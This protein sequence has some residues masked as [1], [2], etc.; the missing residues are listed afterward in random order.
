MRPRNM[1]IYV[2]ERIVYDASES[3]EVTMAKK[4]K[5]EAPAKDWNSTIQKRNNATRIDSLRKIYGTDF[6]PGYASSAKLASLLND[7]GVRS[8]GEYLK[9]LGSYGR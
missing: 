4:I 2:A 5:R 7:S 9:R 1:Y 6:A 3:A 8:L